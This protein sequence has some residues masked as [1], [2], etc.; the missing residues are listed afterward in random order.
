MNISQPDSHA[1]SLTSG[2]EEGGG[3]PAQVAAPAAGALHR[4]LSATALAVGGHGAVGKVG[5]RGVT[6]PGW[7]G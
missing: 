5:E 2:H 3:R 4:G 1:Q 7:D 6:P